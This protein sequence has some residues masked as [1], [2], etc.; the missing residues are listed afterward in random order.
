MN[1]TDLY[2]ININPNPDGAEIHNLFMKFDLGLWVNYP[3]CE[4]FK[5]L[6]LENKLAR[7]RRENLC[8]EWIIKNR[9]L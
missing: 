6:H 4:P 9:K 2:K 1:I 7:L 8:R 3:D 5:E